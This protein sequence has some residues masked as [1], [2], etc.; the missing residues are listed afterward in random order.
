MRNQ[1]RARAG[2]FSFDANATRASSSKTRSINGSRHGRSAATLLLGTCL[3]A[4]LAAPAYAASDTWTGSGTTSNWSDTGNWSAAAAPAN[5]DSVILSQTGAFAPSNFNINV[6]L[7]SLTLDTAGAGTNSLASGYIINSG[8]G[9]LGLASGGSIT[10]NAA[11]N[12]AD[13]INI[14]I[15][16]NGPATISVGS[17]ATGLI[18]GGDITGTGGLTVSNASN[19]SALQFLGTNTYSG[20]TTISSGTLQLGNGGTTGSILG[21]VIDNGTLAFDRSDNLSFDGNISGTGGVTQIGSGTLTLTGANSYAGGTVIANG[22]VSASYDNNLGASGGAIEIDNGSTLELARGF[23]TARDITLVN[24]GTIDAVSNSYGPSIFT[25][26]ISGTGGLSL[27]GSG[28]LQLTNTNTYTGGTAI[29]STNTLSF[30]LSTGSAAG[31]VVGA[32][33]NDGTLQFNRS[34]AATFSNAISGTGKVQKYQTDT[35][36]LTGASSYTGG[37]QIFAGT[38]QLG[39]GATSGT[40]TGDVSL[41]ATGATLAFDETTDTTFAGNITG[42][43]ILSQMGSHTLTV[44][45]AN[46]L[47]GISIGSG[48]T[49]QLG[50]GT[51]GSLLFVGSSGVADNGTL[52]IDLASDLSLSQ[53]ITGSGSLAQIGSGTTTLSGTNTY[54][55]GTTISAGTLQVGNGATSGS[56]TG[57]ITDNATL[58]FYRSDTSTYGGVISGTGAVMQQGVGTT[59]LT[60]ANTYSGGTTIAAGALQIGDGGTAGAIAGDVV[61]NGQFNFDR[62]DSI[63]FS[64]IISGTGSV[65]QM[66]SGTLTLAGANTYSGGTNISGGTLAASSAS[67]LGTGAVT[68]TNGATLQLLAGTDITLEGAMGTGGGTIDTDGNTVTWSGSIADVPGATSN[69]L[70]KTGAGTLILS[71]ANS[72]TG[73]TTISAGMLQIGNGGTSGSIAGDVLDNSVFAFDFSGSLSFGGVISGSGAVNQNGSGTLT[74]SGTNTYTGGTNINAGTVSV[75]SDANLGNGGTIAMAAGTTLKTTATGTFAH[76]VTVTGDPTFNVAPGTTTTWSGLISDGGSAG[77][78][79]IAGGGTFKPTNTANSYSGGTV[80][81]DGGILS[82]G[83]DGELGAASGG[84][85]LGDATTSGTLDVLSSFTLG[86]GRAVSLDAGGGTIDTE[87]GVAFEIAQGISGS[88]KLTVSGAGTLTL[89][90]ASSYAGGTTISG[91]TLQLGDGTTAGTVVGDI[92]DNGALIFNEASDVTMAGAISGNGSLTQNDAT[93]HTLSLTGA[94]TY[95]GGTTITAGALA[96]GD[97]GSTGS[98]AGNILDNGALAFNRADTLTYGGA[99][100][101]TGAVSQIG[102]GTT[103]LTGASSYSGGTTIAAGTLQLGNGGTTGS[104]LGDVADNGALGFDRSDA[105]TFGGVISGTGALSQ[106]GSGTTILTGANSYAGGTTV[107]AGTLQIGNG[108]TAGSILG[109]VADSGTL[110]FDRSDAVTFGGVISGTGALTQIGGGTTIL[111]GANTYSGG[112]TISSG[113]LQVGAGGTLGSIAGTIVDNAALVFDRSDTLSYAGA[114]SGTG[115]LEQAG[116]GTLILTGAST[117]SGGTTVSAGTLQIGNGGTSGSLAGDVADATNLVFDR[118]DTLSFA[119]VISGAGAVVQIGTGTTILTGANTYTGG[120]T[121]SAGTLQ[122]GNAGTSG[123]IAGD[124]ADD[125]TLAFDRSDSV[126]FGGVI[127]GTGDVTQMGT[128][129]LTLTG[130]DTYS[131]ATTVMAGSLLVDGSIGASSGVMVDGGASIGGTGTVSNLTVAS[132]ATIAPGDGGVGTL[133]VAGNLSLGSGAIY[134]FDTTSSGGDLLNVSGTANLGGTLSVNLI[135]SGFTTATQIAVVSANSGLTGTFSSLDLLAG[136]LGSLNPYLSYDAN[137]AYL[138]FMP[139]IASLVPPSG[140]GTN[141]TRIADAIDF[142]IR[143]RNGGLTFLPLASLSTADLKTTL[144]QMTGEVSTGLQNVALSS[145]GSFLGNLLDP[146]VGGRS[147]IADGAGGSVLAGEPS[148][149]RVAYNGPDATMPY[150]SAPRR[151]WNVWGS[152]NGG[153]NQ[154]DGDVALGTTKLTAT[155]YGGILGLDYTPATGNGAIGIA[156][157]LDRGTWNLADNQGKGTSTAYE[158]GLYYSRRFDRNYV[159]AALSYAQYHVTTDRTLD[160]GGT[161]TYHARFTAWSAAARMEAGHSFTAG[162][163]TIT[164]YVRFQAIDL[165]LPHYGETTIAG[166]PSFALT[167]TGKHHFDYTSEAGVAWNRVMSWQSGSTT[168]LH[169]RIGWLHDYSGQLKD[170]A[171]LSTFS[172][173]SFGV[174][175]AALPRDAAHVELGVEHNIDN[176]ALTLNADTTAGSTAQSYGGTASVSYRW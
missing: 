168:D 16:L 20:G 6:T 88:G 173:A 70:T 18:M 21:N 60:G 153:H 175:G 40:I 140:T 57:D 162:A 32:I 146:T 43:G 59:I 64:G 78:V 121:I 139:T 110:A 61:D 114:I 135:G 170:L 77:T 124:V 46:T 62:S 48:S 93:G 109:N 160:L 128:G 148:N 97:G 81:R 165:G 31:S 68:F 33:T 22:T 125:G 69:G 72:Y 76:D 161:N 58:A 56:I 38:L 147:G 15:A 30:G 66:G 75:S 142:A 176:F 117:L 90:T 130:A 143:Y 65:G 63:A 84:L 42:L 17:T 85:T 91:G 120:T 86:A 136:S 13:Q 71:G 98:I 49:L 167:Y 24:G 47:G 141:Q 152:F 156:A 149:V 113:I 36:T 92:A 87:S 100:S 131:G 2:A 150:A 134:A 159:A 118:S 133:N 103:I 55:G 44:T 174:M 102:S 166:S 94:N 151:A 108:G 73:G 106:I 51:N 79:E 14:G 105:I 50:D 29:S 129:T 116:S 111:T 12:A 137:N 123:W 11:N 101:G 7:N 112:T 67:N 3:A 163:N 138:L 25:G 80:V 132:K 122:I 99:I 83:A 27:T 107:A 28:T 23:S 154:N 10:D 115:T 119:G 172:G 164:P 157:G 39:D 158:T 145:V 37:T 82:I 53:D 4:L 26:V 34:N 1:N 155:R 104:I 52:S 19:A 169:A 9:T 74:L 8:G 144:A 41:L 45:G 126:S 96:I 127:S 95:T 171:T 89:V 5:G 35:I 54:S